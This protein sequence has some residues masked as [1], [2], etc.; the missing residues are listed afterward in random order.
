MRL[1]IFTSSTNADSLLRS[2]LFSESTFYK[3]FSRDVKRAQKEVVIESPFITVRRAKEFSELIKKTQIQC[4]VFTRNPNHHSGTLVSESWDGIRL[5][6]KAGIKVIVC[7]DM[8]HRKIAII[9][10]HILWEGS[11]N[12]LSQN[13]SKEIMRR[14]DSTELCKQMRT[15][16]GLKWYSRG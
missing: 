13:G 16:I 6:R 8:R 14:S 1:S 2:D 10:H 9:D 5:L 4:T 12:M 11:L 3:A 15:F 7:D